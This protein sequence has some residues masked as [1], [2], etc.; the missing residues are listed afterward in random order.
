MGLYRS[1]SQEVPVT[2]SSQPE[3]NPR[4]SFRHWMSVCSCQTHH[5]VPN[6]DFQNSDYSAL[7]WK[8]LFLFDFCYCY[9]NNNQSQLREDRSYFVLTAY[10]AWWQEFKAGVWSEKL[11]Q[12]PQRKVSHWLALTAC[13]QSAFLHNPGPSAQGW[14]QL[15]PSQQ[16]LVKRI[17]QTCPQAGLIEQFLKLS[18]VLAG[19]FSLCQVG[20]QIAST[21]I[22]GS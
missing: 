13:P 22:K 5:V 20:E 6:N 15:Y 4:L 3:A 8:F 9:K 21:V 17:P 2:C 14:H 1:G 16:S 11:K 18:S 19:D 7:D 10:R 12:R